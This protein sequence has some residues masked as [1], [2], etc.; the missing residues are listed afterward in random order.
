MIQIPPVAKHMRVRN[1]HGIAR[2]FVCSATVAAPPMPRGTFEVR[3]HRKL[4]YLPVVCEVSPPST[5]K[6][7]FS[8]S[9]QDF[10]LTRRWHEWRMA[11]T[12]PA[13]RLG[14]CSRR[15]TQ[16]RYKYRRV[17][18]VGKYDHGKPTDYRLAVLVS[19]L[20]KRSVRS[21]RC[22]TP[23]VRVHN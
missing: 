3:S 2:G 1:N 6:T 11:D 21:C 12:C 19:L 13:L 20:T 10:A 7:S 16:E 9:K 4:Q 17:T 23:S 8:V 14:P 15:R 22:D 5:S 18:V